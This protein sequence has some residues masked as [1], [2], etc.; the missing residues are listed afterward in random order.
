MIE[1]RFCSFSTLTGNC[2]VS[3][4]AKV[5]ITIGSVT[6]LIHVYV[7]K[8]DCVD[9]LLGLDNIFKFN[10]SFDSNYNISQ[11]L[12]NTNDEPKMIRLINPKINLP[13]NFHIDIET[14]LKSINDDRR[15]IELM[16][17]FEFVFSDNKFKVGCLKNSICIIEL[18]SIVPINS[19][20]Y[21]PSFEEQKTIDNE[22]KSLL[23]AGLIQP[24]HSPY[25]SPVTLAFKKDD[26]AKTRFCI[27]YRKLNDKTIPDK[28]PMPR[29][30]DIIDSLHGNKYFSVFDIKSGFWHI[31]MK[32]E[33]IPKTAFVTQNGHYEWKVMPFGFKNAPAIFQRS[34]RNLIEKHSLTKFC[35]NYIDDIIVYS[36]NRSI[37]IDHIEKL[38][39]AVASEGIKLNFEKC[40]FA[41]LSVNYLG[42]ILC[43]NEIRPLHSNVDSILKLTPPKTIK[44][45]RRFLGK[46]NYNRKFIENITLILE[47]LHQLLRK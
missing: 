9:L 39:V 23:E 3:G 4:L 11:K 27:D 16:K 20:P 7:T 35:H 33:D 19:K 44:E 43:L 29:I 10:L 13:L 18:E 22:I 25:A 1:D 17:K 8:L 28:Y 42:H 14:K 36:P 45:L 37:H 2:F 31:K 30:E 5:K 46:V 34:I 38:L 32:E 26:N 41:Q 12:M 47:P 40:K 24:S 6:K 21:R 15:L